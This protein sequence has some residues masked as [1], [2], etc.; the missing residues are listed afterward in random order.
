MYLKYPWVK[1]LRKGEEKFNP[2]AFD[3]HKER[4]DEKEVDEVQAFL[5]PG[6][7]EHKSFINARLEEPKILQSSNPMMQPKKKDYLGKAPWF[8]TQITNL[9]DTP[10]P[11]AYESEVKAKWFKQSFNKIFADN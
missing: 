10:G 8:G 6:Y 5:G 4:F 11:G 1:G 7:Y 9:I 2:P 3:S